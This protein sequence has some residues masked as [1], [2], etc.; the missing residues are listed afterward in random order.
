MVF[1]H[2]LGHRNY[3]VLTNCWG[4]QTDNNIN[5]FVGNLSNVSDNTFTLYFFRTGDAHRMYP[6]IAHIVIVGRNKP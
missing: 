2:N 3:T 6:A 5:P 1:P 4:K